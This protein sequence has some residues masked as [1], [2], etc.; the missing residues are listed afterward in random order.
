[1]YIKEFEVCPAYISKI[2]SNWEKQIIILMIPNEEREGWHYLAVKKLS[3][4]LKGIT[5]KNN[6]DSCYC[7]CLHSFKKEN[8]LKSHKKVCKNKDFCGIALPSQKDNISKFSQYMKSDKTPCI[9]YSES[10]TNKQTSKIL[11]KKISEHIPRGYSTSTIWVFDNIENKH[12][13]YH[14]EDSMKKFCISF[15]KHAANVINFEK[16]ITLPIT[17]KELKLHQDS[18]VCY[19]CR[20]KFTQKVAKDKN[21]PKFRDYCHFTGKRRGATHSLCHL[22]TNV[23]KEIFIVF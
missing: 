23:S 13:L 21:Y 20:E 3:A 6:G 9:I 4:L 1:M 19:N 14:G 2:D 22:R 7:H 11:N 17:E 18:M 5:S 15:R 12:S 10:M 8:K 16:N